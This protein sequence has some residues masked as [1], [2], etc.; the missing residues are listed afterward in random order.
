MFTRYDQ[1]NTYDFEDGEFRDW[2]SLRSVAYRKMPNMSILMANTAAAMDKT[3][4]S[5][6][7]RELFGQVAS[8]TSSDYCTGCCN[9]CESAV[10]GE[11]PIG[12]VMR[13]LMYSRSYGDRDRAKRKFQRIP[14]EVRERMRTIDYSGAEDICPQ[15]M[16]IAHLMHAALDELS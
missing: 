12:K 6:Y 13:Y 10:G 9:N 16:Q 11:V 4:I 3:E 1:N 7:D 14:F 8:E 15:R 5:S 2:K